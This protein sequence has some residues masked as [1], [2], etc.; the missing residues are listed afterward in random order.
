M[1]ELKQKLMADYRKAKR[2]LQRLEK[3]QIETPT[4]EQKAEIDE[5]KGYCRGLMRA[6][7]RALAHVEVGQNQTFPG[8]GSLEPMR[9]L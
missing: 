5:M 6:Y 4:S 2:W 3:R 1:E 7:K 8:F 9:N